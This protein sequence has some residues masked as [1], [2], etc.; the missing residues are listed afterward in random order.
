MCGTSVNRAALIGIAPAGIAIGYLGLACG[1]SKAP[2]SWHV[3]GHEIVLRR[4]SFALVQAAMGA[5]K[6]VADGRC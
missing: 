1:L 2:D 6:L 4:S 5:A 3:R